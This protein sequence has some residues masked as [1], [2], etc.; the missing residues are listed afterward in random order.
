MTRYDKIKSMSVE[1]MAQI[2]MDKDITDDF[3]KGSGGCDWSTTLTKEI[4][5]KECLR[6]CI[7]WLNAEEV[8]RD[9]LL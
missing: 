6:C 5:E 7:D 4:D 9:D 1:E 3:C 8:T 2:I